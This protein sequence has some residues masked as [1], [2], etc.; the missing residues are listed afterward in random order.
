MSEQSTTVQSSFPDTEDFDPARRATLIAVPAE[1]G[2]RLDFHLQ[3][4]R[5]TVFFRV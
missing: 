4:P 2:Y 1:D 3:G 5:E